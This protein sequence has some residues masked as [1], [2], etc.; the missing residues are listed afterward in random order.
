MR[1]MLDTCVLYPAM[2]RDFLLALAARG[3]FVP[4]WSNGVAA[5]LLSLVAR[6]NP[7]ELARIQALLKQMTARWPEGQTTPGDADT[8]DLPDKTDRHV[9]AAAMAGKADAILTD[10]WR[11]FPNAALAPHGLRAITPDDFVMQLWLKAPDSV[12]ETLATQWPGL[13]GRDLRRVL[14]RA[15]M[16]RLGK[17]LEH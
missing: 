6:R 10:N 11:D 8:P 3:L 4:L 15:G 13:A 17:A 14:R 16:P 2:L 7:A 5:E 12:S 1:V 9:L